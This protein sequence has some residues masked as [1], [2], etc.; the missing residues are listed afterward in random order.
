MIQ[1]TTQLLPLVGA[2][3]NRKWRGEAQAPRWAWYAMMTIIAYVSTLDARFAAIYA[4]FLLGYA[5]A[6]WQAMFSAVNGHAPGRS[7]S[8]YFQWMQE[9]TYSI[10]GI[11]RILV[12]VEKYWYNFGIVYGTIRAT[13]MIP[14]IFMLAGYTSSLVPF[15]GLG[16]L[17]MGYIYYLG[18]KLSRYWGISESTGVPFSEIPMGYLITAYMLV[19]GGLNG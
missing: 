4:L 15:I 17:S 1:E 5:M 14:G 7:D 8:A 19:C 13:L 12:D 10:C 6:P 9:I 3:L 16:F 18:G 2:G 11:P